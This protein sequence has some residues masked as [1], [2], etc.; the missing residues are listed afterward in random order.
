MSN[1]YQ[2]PFATA[3][4]A[5]IY[6]QQGKLEQ[7]KAMFERLL[8]DDPNDERLKAGLREADRR[9]ASDDER[10]SLSTESVML[11]LAEGKPRCHWSLTPSAKER[12][13]RVLGSRG[14]LTLRLVGFP[15]DPGLMPH[16]TPLK[17]ETGALT[18]VPPPGALLIAASVGV[19][20][21]ENRFVSIAHS[22]L[23]QL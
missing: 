19:L 7:A 15:A 12:A 21:Q 2:Q 5:Q 10:P 4:I 16:D 18:L 20:N 6:L 17:Q 22:D 8:R 3:T 1:E 14:Q 9:L 23:V 11:K 13:E